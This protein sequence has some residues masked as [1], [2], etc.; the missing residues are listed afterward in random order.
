ME[1]KYYGIAVLLLA[2]MIVI[3]CTEA[4]NPDPAPGA[5][6]IP[7]PANGVDVGSIDTAEEAVDATST[8]GDELEDIGSELDDID[9]LV[10]DN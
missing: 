4:A 3:G 10:E 7:D 8:I 5:I 6:S 1:T 2:L 9:S